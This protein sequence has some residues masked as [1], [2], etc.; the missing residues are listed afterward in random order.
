MV[1]EAGATHF[2]NGKIRSPNYGIN[3]GTF[4][5]GVNYR[6]NDEVNTREITLNDFHE[7]RFYG[8]YNIR[9]PDPEP[10]Y[11]VAVL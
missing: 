5:L 1:L 8:I 9:S 4:S 3:A 2:S 7:V 10:D 6:F 11:I